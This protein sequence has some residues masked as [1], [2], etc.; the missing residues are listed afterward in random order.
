MFDKDIVACPIGS[1]P[2][3]SFFLCML[4]IIVTIKCMNAI[5]NLYI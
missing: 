1:I 3:I 4:L 2:V 5:L